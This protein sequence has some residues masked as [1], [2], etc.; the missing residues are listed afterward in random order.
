MLTEKQQPVTELGLDSGSKHMVQKR[1]GRARGKWHCR[2][3][4]Q[5]NLGGY[6]WS[7]VVGGSVQ[8]RGRGK[9]RL[10]GKAMHSGL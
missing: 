2:Q 8:G 3:K 5:R 6:T 7:R 1:A 9:P 4:E 10:E